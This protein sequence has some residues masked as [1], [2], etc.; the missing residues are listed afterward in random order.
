M[1]NR[2]TVGIFLLYIF[3]FNNLYGQVKFE[4]L[5]EKVPKDNINGYFNPFAK[6]FNSAIN[7]GLY[8]TASTHRTGGFDVTIKGMVVFLPDDAKTFLSE[9]NQSWSTIFGPARSSS[10]P[11]E[12]LNPGGLDIKRIPIAVP[13][14][15]V[16]VG[17]YFEIMAR[18][19]KFNLGDY[20]DVS[21]YGIGLKHNLKRY[22]LKL[23]GLPNLSVQGVYQMFKVGDIVD[24][25][26]WALNAH[27]SQNLLLMTLYG[28]AGLESMTIDLNYKVNNPG[29]PFDGNNVSV[30]M[31]EYNS[32]RLVGGIMVKFGLLNLN[33]EVNLAKYRTISGGVGITFR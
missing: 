4:E 11:L 14:A 17:D 28:G 10:L 24:S 32:P 9:K 31:K 15:S 25:K 8:H 22:F 13:Q 23:P 6:A 16:G 2:L 7:S 5:I 29:S 19:L 12:N 30:V 20:G 18:F 1:F 3:S 21:L 26:S 33:L 27:I